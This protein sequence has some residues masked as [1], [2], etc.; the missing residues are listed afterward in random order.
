[1]MP[2]CNPSNPPPSVPAWFCGLVRRDECL[3]PRWRYLWPELAALV[4]QESRFRPWALRSETE[5]RE[6]PVRS[7]AEAVAHV[8][9]NPG[10]VY[11]AGLG[12][13]TGS[14]LVRWYGKEWWRKAFDGC[15]GLYALTIHFVT[16]NLP[17]ARARYN[18]SG[19]A[20]ATHAMRVAGHLERITAG[21]AVAPALPVVVAQ[22]AC[23]DAPPS[24]AMWQ[25]ARW[26]SCVREERK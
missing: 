13:I 4:Q 7:V 11:G 6:V 2:D 24:W 26:R 25:H 17:V 22:S 15:N 19:P 10:Q 8:R 9:A 16:D 3:P 20:A 21:V 1:M 12:Q 14:N 5:D 23:G 18:G